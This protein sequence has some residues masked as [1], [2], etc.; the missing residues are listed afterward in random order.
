[1]SMKP[2]RSIH[3]VASILAAFG[4]VQCRYAMAQEQ[5]S[6]SDVSISAQVGTL[7]PGAQLGLLLSKNVSIRLGVNGYTDDH[8]ATNPTSLTTAIF[9]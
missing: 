8:S 7:G 9:N 2:L 5:P 1:M 3:Q 6:N 4:S